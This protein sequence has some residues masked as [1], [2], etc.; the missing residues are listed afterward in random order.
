MLT[1][2][3][4]STL[5]NEPSSANPR[6]FSAAELINCAA[7]LRPN[8]PNRVNCLYCGF[9][10]SGA[11]AIEQ[12]QDQAVKRAKTDNATHIVVASRRSDPD[13]NQIS[14]AAALVGI[15]TPEFGRVV[16]AARVIPICRTP[17]LADAE[18]VR[19]KLTS[20]GFE[21]IIISEQHLDLESPPID[22]RALEMC[23][24]SV[25]AFGTRGEPALS[26]P[27]QDVTLVV[28]GH[29]HFSTVEV[30][31]RGKRNQ[32]KIVAERRLSTDEAVLDIY[33]RHGA[34]PWR[35]KGN[36]FDFSCLRE[37]K[38]ITAFDN[39]V[40]LI[41]LLRQHAKCADFNDDYV[42][43]RRLL[44][45]IWPTENS[46]QPPQRRRAGWREIEATASHSSNE[47][48]FNCYSR[49]LRL[50]SEQN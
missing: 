39:F 13:E 29:L 36:S 34:V 18:A 3:T 30:E 25:S 26:A 37:Q 7:C 27:W 28:M 15:G 1:E 48:Q 49:L 42:R 44:D 32:R 23:D 14:K 47:A 45:K 6:G 5:D 10:L 50:L 21:P 16:E 2:E 40:S 35:I 8:P 20:P 22:I 11:E 41:K 9:A 24:E 33:Y 19:G 43:L 46:E 31:Q 38:A 4:R 12:Y 17:A